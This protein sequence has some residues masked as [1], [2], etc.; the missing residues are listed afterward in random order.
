M[1]YWQLSVGFS[2]GYCRE[3]YT[4]TLRLALWHALRVTPPLGAR[5]PAYGG[6]YYTPTLRFPCGVPCGNRQERRR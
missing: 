5:G 6:E 1:M 3:Y 2:S 4:P